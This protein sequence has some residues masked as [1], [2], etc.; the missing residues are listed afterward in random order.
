[1]VLVNVV[2]V[3]LT[4]QVAVLPRLSVTVTLP[5]WPVTNAW[6]VF[7]DG[8]LA[9]GATPTLIVPPFKVNVV[10]VSPSAAEA[11]RVLAASRATVPTPPAIKARVLLIVEDLLWFGTGLPVSA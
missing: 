6:P 1:M 5:I 9:F 7:A 2:E 3:A 4:F 8:R 11:G 10:W